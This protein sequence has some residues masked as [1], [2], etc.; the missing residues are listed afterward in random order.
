MGQVNNFITHAQN[1][2]NTE[3]RLLYDVS[4]LDDTLN[5]IFTFSSDFVCDNTTNRISND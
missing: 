2:M 1:T 3:Y 4:S 5:M